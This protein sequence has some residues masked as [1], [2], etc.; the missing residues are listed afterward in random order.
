M[1]KY[2]TLFEQV[3]KARALN[4]WEPSIPEGKHQVALVKYGG[5]TSGKDK[6]VFLEAEFIV[7][8]TDNEKV[9][10]GARYSWPW[11]INR[12]DEFGYTASRAK[13]FLLTVQKCIGNE[14]DVSLFGSALAEDFD[15]DQPQAYGVVMDVA[16]TPVKDAKGLPRRGKKGNEVYNASWLPVPQS[17]ADITVTRKKLLEL[18]KAR[19]RPVTSADP[20]TMNGKK[21]E[22]D[23]LVSRR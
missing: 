14:E 13:D 5:K 17:E 10:V 21:A 4:N 7:V 3:G 2:E 20:M 8:E 23:T 22:A 11:F 6:T 19:G 1:G 16:V 9:R 12:A 15:G 18:A